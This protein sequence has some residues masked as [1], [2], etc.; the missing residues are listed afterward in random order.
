MRKYG[1]L[2]HSL[3]DYPG[4]VCS[5]VFMAGCNFHCPYCHN[6]NLATTIESEGWAL[7]EIVDYLVEAKSLI[8]AVCISGGE[9]TLYPETLNFLV[10]IFKKLGFKVKV[11]TNGSH[12]EQIQSLNAL[13][14]YFAMDLKTSL[15]RYSEVC[16]GDICNQVEQSIQLLLKRNPS[17]YEFRTTLAWEF[18]NEEVITDLGKRLSKDTAWYLQRCRYNPPLSTSELTQET[19]RIQKLLTLAKQ[20]TDR[21]FFRE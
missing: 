14:D 17:A 18:V 8:T 9:P 10:N 15:A 13:V 16:N 7:N 4:E 1:F 20:Y 19:E 2:K 21:V 11:D 3:V 12:P 6:A 5:V